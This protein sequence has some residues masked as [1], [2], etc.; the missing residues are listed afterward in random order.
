MS[1]KRAA[2]GKLVDSPCTEP[3]YGLPT[4]GGTGGPSGSAAAQPEAAAS[5]KLTDP[6]G[7]EPQYGLPTDG[8]AGGAS[9]S[10]TASVAQHHAGWT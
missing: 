4:D 10:A 6:P 2:S 8:G 1:M 3:R 5:G 7:T 9:G